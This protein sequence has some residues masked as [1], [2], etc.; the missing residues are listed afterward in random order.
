M[1]WNFSKNSS[2]LVAPPFPNRCLD[3]KSSNEYMVGP[4]YTTLHNISPPHVSAFGGVG[5]LGNLV[6]I[7]VLLSKEMRKN[8]FNN[9]LTA[10]NITDSLHIVFAILEVVRVD[11]N[12]VYNSFLPHSF[13]PYFHYP[14]YRICLCASIYLIMAGDCLKNRRNIRDA[15]L[16]QS[17]SFLTLFKR[18]GGQTHVQKEL[19]NS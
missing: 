3:I 6:S 14:A 17:C 13:F 2:D 8:C 10:L 19:Q 4:H 9:I 12:L 1:V 5:L 11:F 7:A 16:Y 18:G 15:P